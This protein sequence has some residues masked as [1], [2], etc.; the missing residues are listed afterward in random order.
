MSDE[1]LAEAWGAGRSLSPGEAV[2]L[3]LDGHATSL[4]DYPCPGG[5]IA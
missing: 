1:V 5:A 2:A 3:A 4:A